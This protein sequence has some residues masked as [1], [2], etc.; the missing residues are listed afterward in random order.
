MASSPP[1]RKPSKPLSKPLGFISMALLASIII[2]YL[3]SA[4]SYGGTME[5]N[6]AAFWMLRSWKIPA[7]YDLRWN[8]SVTDCGIPLD[9]LAS[10]PAKCNGFPWT[11]YPFL[12]FILG[13]WLGFK[14]IDVGWIGFISCVAMLATLG[15]Q[16]WLITSGSKAC[17]LLIFLL[18]ACFPAQMLL[19][20]NNL[21]IIV[22]VLLSLF[23]LLIWLPS[24][25]GL[26]SST[27]LGIILTALKIYP[28]FGIVSLSLSWLFKKNTPK[29]QKF[30]SLILI[31]TQ[32]IAFAYIM[33]T[34]KSNML[35]KEGQ[36]GS[37]GLLA[38][39]YINIISIKLY[40]LQ[41]ARI[42]IK[43]MIALKLISLFFGAILSF[44]FNR[45]MA[46]K[47]S[48]S[49][50]LPVRSYNYIYAVI[51]IMTCIGILGYAITINYD[52]RL[53]FFL[54]AVAVLAENLASNRVLV[55]RQRLLL[56]AT[57]FMATYCLFLPLVFNSATSTTVFY[58]ELIDE[59]M[60][61][62]FFIGYTTSF[63][64]LLIRDQ[65]FNSHRN[66]FSMNFC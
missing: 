61:A 19:E 43:A 39:G 6:P 9:I 28:F 24:N 65:A 42:F 56:G 51:V 3:Y 44:K 35:I 10:S 4:F 59:M 11:G 16:L 7:F 31:A 37:H 30:F 21:D 27:S 49:K 60:A 20:R 52:Y 26:V 62:P 34:L 53:I 5:P 32:V 15:H 8:L 29:D 2:Y 50:S 54:P 22:Y 63:L 14:I 46:L 38:M 64:F 48:S 45:H 66:K 23:C 36:L 18:L 57:L 33:V 47:I 40:G 25:F 13:R 12:A 41:M 55:A 17:Y 58:L 1:N